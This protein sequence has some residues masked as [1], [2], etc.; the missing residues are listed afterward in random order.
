MNCGCEIYE[1]INVFANPCDETVTLPIYALETGVYK[2]VNE[3]NGI[4]VRTDI[5]ATIGVNITI[6]TTKFNENYTHVV[7]FYKEDG[8]ILNNTCYKLKIMQTVFTNPSQETNSGL[9]GQ[10]VTGNG[11]SSQTF[12]FLSGH[13]LQSI[14]ME[15]QTLNKAQFTQTGTTI[16]ITLQ[17]LVFQGQVY[18]QYK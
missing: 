7:Q 11:N 3:F 17:G 16:T 12:S 2:M 1:C 4:I 5:S 10:T 9:L 8:S 13:E 14:T 15:L 6:P 18:L